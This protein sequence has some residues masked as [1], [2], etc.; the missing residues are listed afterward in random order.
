MNRA[1]T[2]LFGTLSLVLLSGCMSG[3]DAAAPQG[4]TGVAGTA[5]TPKGGMPK[6]L[7]APIVFGSFDAEAPDFQLFKPCEEIPA[8]VYREI[9]LGEKQ[10]DNHAIGVSQ[11]C[12]FRP[13]PTRGE[14]QVYTVGV[15]IL[16]RDDAPKGEI[17]VLEGRFHDNVEVHRTIFPDDQD[18]SCRLSI[19]TSRGRLEIQRLDG[20]VVSQDQICA[21]VFE[22]SYSLIDFIKGE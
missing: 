19:W 5:S 20:E 9:G 12:F 4:T 3:D 22:K 10:G 8:E 6:S 18:D 21:D 2:T 1:L 7:V 11:Y 14:S 13:D 17:S 16:R 15:D